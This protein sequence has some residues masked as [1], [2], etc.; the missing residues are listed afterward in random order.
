MTSAEG[1]DDGAT[2]DLEDE[3]PGSRRG[4]P[5]RERLREPDSYGLLFFGLIGVIVVSAALSSYEWGRAITFLL[6][7]GTLLFAL[8]T[9]RAP[10]R[11]RIA[12]E[13]LFPLVVIFS[14]VAVVNGEQSPV[15][16][17]V[18]G[19]V[20]LLHVAVLVA[21]LRRMATHLVISWQ[22]VMASLCIYLLIG[23]TFAALFGFLG[24]IYSEGVFAGNPPVNTV[25]YLYFS[26]ITVTTVGYGDLTPGPDSIRMLAVTE[27]LVGQIFLVT[28]LALLVGNLGRQRRTPPTT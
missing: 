18:S 12:A 7:G 13:V 21:I 3:I 10:R 28:A 25:D 27:A 19:L 9:S 2:I 15:K 14:V 11:L 5:I 26:F 8:W 24:E 1:T 22:T 20:L 4:T 16:E 6:M 23:M 17:I